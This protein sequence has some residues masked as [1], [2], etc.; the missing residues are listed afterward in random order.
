MHVCTKLTL[1]G[2]SAAL[3]KSSLT[4]SIRVGL[5]C[6]KCENEH[7]HM[8]MNREKKPLF[9]SLIFLTEY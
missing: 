3:R 2:A 7:V 1:G 6:R 9:A 5:M 8:N 4:K